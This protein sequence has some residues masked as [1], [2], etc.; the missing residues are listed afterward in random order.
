MDQR[1][2]EIIK[3]HNSLNVPSYEGVKTGEYTGFMHVYLSYS[4][5]NHTMSSSADNNIVLELASIDQF[6]DQ[7]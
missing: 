2:K 3:Q 5:N 4:K 6:R 1:A 7:S